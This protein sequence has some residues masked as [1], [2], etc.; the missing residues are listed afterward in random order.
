MGQTLSEPVVDKVIALNAIPRPRTVR[1]DL[2]SIWTT[3]PDGPPSSAPSPCFLSLR[4]DLC[5]M[6]EITKRRW[7]IHHLW[8][9]IDAGMAN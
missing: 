7:R 6:V 5:A 8:R 4:A 2:S 1:F 9:V 3:A